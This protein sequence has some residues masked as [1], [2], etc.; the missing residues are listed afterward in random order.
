MGGVRRRDGRKGNEVVKIQGNGCHGGKR[1]EML[2]TER[3]GG[4]GG[5][6]GRRMEE[7]RG[8]GGRLGRGLGSGGRAGGRGGES[9]RKG[10]REF[11][12]SV[13]EL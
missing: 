4:F 5:R 10:S 12:R 1:L 3:K 9:G 11:G 13:Y 6:M 7:G 8:S 2:W